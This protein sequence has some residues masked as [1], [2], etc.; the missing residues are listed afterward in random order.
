MMA[1]MQGGRDRL[2]PALTS[3]HPADVESSSTA[4]S[5]W[6]GYWLT[7]AP[8]TL[9]STVKVPVVH[10]PSGGNSL[11]TEWTYLQGSVGFA[12][13]ALEIACNN[14]SLAYSGQSYY[15]PTGSP[16][17]GKDV[18]WSFSPA[19]GNLITSDV[20]VKTNGSLA[21]DVSDTT[22]SKSTSLT[23]SCAAC[24]GSDGGV[25]T[26]PSTAPVPS[27]GTVD[28]TGVTVNG[29][30]LQSVKPTLV[31]D[32]CGGKV[33]VTTSSIAANG[34]AFTNSYAGQC[35]LEILSSS[36]PGA[37][38]GTTYTGS[39][40]AQGGEPPYKWSIS[41][42]SLPTGTPASPFRLGSSTS[43]T[44]VIGGTPAVAGTY[45]FTV[46][47]KDASGAAAS[48][49]QSIAV[50]SSVSPTTFTLA[51]QGVPPIHS[52]HVAF[53]LVGNWWCP[54]VGSTRT[55]AC[56]GS[57]PSYHC[58][59]GYTSCIQETTD[60]VAA[61]HD[62]IHSDYSDSGTGGYDSGIAAFDGSNG[63]VGSGL[64]ENYYKGSDFAGPV[65]TSALSGLSVNEK[66]VPIGF[67]RTLN[68]FAGGWGIQSQSDVADTVI[69]VVNAPSSSDCAGASF[70]SE[71]GSGGPGLYGNFNFAFI[72][73][74]DANYPDTSC[75]PHALQHVTADQFATF[76]ASHEIDEAITSPLSHG[77]YVD[78]GQI[79]DPCNTRNLVGK[80]IQDTG[81]YWNFTRDRLGTVVASYVSPLTNQCFPN[82]S[83]SVPPG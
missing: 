23:G 76:A 57:Q 21:I 56:T 43:T 62:L 47:V 72:Q 65:P 26:F 49:S 67:Q 31:D 24:A 30:S 14:G 8:L 34:T 10:C 82:V 66:S 6:A 9:A 1:V 55:S 52:P 5:D 20:S 48:L 58:N 73:L 37:K 32:S 11:L 29:G 36:L 16:S 44:S 41:A 45:T 25:Q 33:V 17:G 13:E 50:S 54:L 42:G 59:V 53:L 83:T 18:A 81:P 22:H 28:W 35:G 46:S 78:G 74:E 3:T 27:F 7:N 77:W 12:A 63:S 64:T 19:A 71:T 75:A 61:L 68:S 69:V 39:I 15:E 51:T 40:Q 60:I 4:T 2:A 38:V 80:V 70:N 79:A